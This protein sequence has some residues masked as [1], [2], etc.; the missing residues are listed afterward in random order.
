VNSSEN[1]ANL[2]SELSQRLQS[3]QSAIAPCHNHAPN[4]VKDWQRSHGEIQTFF[5]TQIVNTALE[6]TSHNLSVQVEIDK[7]LKML[8]VDLTMLQTARSPDT[9]QKRH[10]QSC[11]RL[12]KLQSYCK[13]QD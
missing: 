1:Y 6:I 13:M 11:D 9:W 5:Q 3:L 10:Q 2:I 4:L 7:Q 12:T 8:G